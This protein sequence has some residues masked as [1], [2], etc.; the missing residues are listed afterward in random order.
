MYCLCLLCYISVN[1]ILLLL[2]QKHMTDIFGWCRIQL[3]KVGHVASTLHCDTFLIVFLMSCWLLYFPDVYDVVCMICR[4]R[5]ILIKWQWST[6]MM[7][8]M[9]FLSLRFNGHFPGEPGLA[10]VY[11][12]E[13]WW[14]W[15][16]Q[17]D[18]RSD[19][20]CK[21]PVKSSP[22]TNQ[23]PVFLQ[24]RCPSCRPTNSVKAL[25]WKNDLEIPVIQCLQFGW[26]RVVVYCCS[27]SRT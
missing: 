7:L 16:W 5:M 26:H 12:S 11:W 25:F 21:A 15:W 20:S 17:L 1:E 19:K 18:Y 23:H 8:S 10:S 3:V 6:D 27:A 13:G 4:I 2:L 9:I 24:A 14:R 22:P